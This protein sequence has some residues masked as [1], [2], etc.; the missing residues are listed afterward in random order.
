MKNKFLSLVMILF[1]VI[2]YFKDETTKSYSGLGDN[3]VLV[4]YRMIRI[5][6]ERYKFDYYN[7]D[8]IK[9]IEVR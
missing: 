6:V 1:L 8:D 3:Q 4:Q 5:H 2:I 7:I 9:K